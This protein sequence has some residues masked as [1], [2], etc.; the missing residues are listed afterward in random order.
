MI[1]IKDPNIPD[2]NK[3]DTGENKID[4]LEQKH[5]GRLNY[6]RIIARYLL[7]AVGIAVISIFTLRYLHLVNSN[8]KIID[9]Y[10][11]YHDWQIFIIYAISMC[12]TASLIIAIFVALLK[13]HKIK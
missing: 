10:L 8:E 1:E 2:N 6:Y 13:F 7:L 11:T 3:S 12:F 5:Q 4:S 9:L